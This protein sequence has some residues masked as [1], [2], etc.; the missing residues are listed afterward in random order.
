MLKPS[1]RAPSNSLSSIAPGSKARAALF[2]FMIYS[3]G[4]PGKRRGSLIIRSSLEGHGDGVPAPEA[5]RGQASPRVASLHFV[6]KGDEHASAARPDRMAERDRPAV[7]VQA[8]GIDAELARDGD[9]LDGEG[10]VQLDEIDIVKVPAGPLKRGADRGN[11]SHH[12]QTGLDSARRLRDD[13]GEGLAAQAARGFGRSDDEGGGPVVDA[14]RVARGH[15]AAFFESGLQV[16]EGFERRVL[17]RPL[18][19]SDEERLALLLGHFDRYDLAVEAPFLHGGDR[20]AVR[21]E[22]ELVLLFA[23]DVVP[24]CDDLARVPHVPVVKGAP[25]AVGYHRID[26]LLV[27]EPVAL[28]R[29]PE[30]VRRVRHRF[31]AAGDRRFVLA[32]FYG[33]GREHDGL[34][35]RAADLVDR[36]GGDGVRDTRAQGDLPGGV[37]PVARLHD[38]PHDDLVYD[39][40]I[41]ARP[42]YGGAGGDHPEVDR[43]EI[44]ELPEQLADGRPRARKYHYIRHIQSTPFRRG[45][46]PA[47][48]GGRAKIPS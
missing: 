19:R 17:A 25:E 5:E 8:R 11:G 23:R 42:L 46:A 48:E 24:L 9:G 3:Y 30:Q 47:L 38:V 36:E 7:Y 27:A 45:A 16:R 37:L 22:R 10:F 21:V 2:L 18:V 33:V 39:L 35:S 41:Y 32:G 4:G 26:H 43:A 40:R 29:I 34:Q 1:A 12:D 15:A 6:K 28:P 13:A 31:H 44:L 14:G 20:L